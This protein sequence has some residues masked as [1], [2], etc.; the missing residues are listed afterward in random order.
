M[1]SYCR[2]M[3]NRC[4]VA[5]QSVE[6]CALS[7]IQHQGVRGLPLCTFRLSISLPTDTT[8]ASASAT[9]SALGVSRYL[10]AGRSR[11][12]GPSLTLLHEVCAPLTQD[13]IMSLYTFELFEVPNKTH[14][15]P[16][17]LY[18]TVVSGRSF[19]SVN[20]SSTCLLRVF[21]DRSCAASYEIGVDNDLS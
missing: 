6:V 9:K 10:H 5:M 12:A 8:V 2:D 17:D 21:A 14:A 11:V 19:I 3:S 18:M 16:T 7:K 20:M 4:T 1:C 13:F 15:L